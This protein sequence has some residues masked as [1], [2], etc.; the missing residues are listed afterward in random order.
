MA[1]DQLK[2]DALHD[3]LTGLPNRVC[4]ANQ[5]AETMRAAGHDN[6]AVLFLD[7]D[8]FKVINDSLGHMVG[9]Q[10]L[11]EVAV[12][13]RS[14]LR[15]RDMLARFGGDEFVV[16]LSALSNV[17]AAVAVAERLQA[18]LASPFE[19]SGHRLFTSASIGIAFADAR[20]QAPQD[21][22]RDADTAMYYA[23]SDGKARCA[24]FDPDHYELAV[25]R[26]ELETDLRHALELNELE[27]YYQPLISVATGEM[28]AVEALLR[29][30]HPK[31]GFLLPARFIPMAEETGLILPIGEWLLNVACRQLGR[32]HQLGFTSLRLTVNISA[33]QL[34]DQELPEL[35]GRVLAEQALDPRFLE[36][37]L[38][39]VKAIDDY[40]RALKTILQL[41]EM[42]VRI[43]MDDFGH[44]TSMHSLKKYPVDTL[45]IDQS[46]IRGTG[47]KDVKKISILRAIVAVGHSLNLN[48]VAEGVETEEQLHLI[49]E[50]QCDE[51][52]G[53]LIGQPMP[54]DEVVRWLLKRAA[55]LGVG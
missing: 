18:V 8:R 26:W 41:R 10:L 22:I 1:E 50:L 43:S 23:K 30:R 9:D 12:R 52:Q 6:V 2:H 45:K 5:L 24:V 51:A 38:T 3:V 29:W 15:A 44:D 11:K 48:I 47:R 34:R 27:P 17:Q 4:F 31:H 25:A 19:L 49:Q 33:R 20:H 42:A 39:D 13:L 46:Y 55:P 54:A 28:V 37:E 40:T 21:L 32:W 35:V 7:L 53:F 16:L 36:L 14:C